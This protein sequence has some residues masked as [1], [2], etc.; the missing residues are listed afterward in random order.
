MVMRYGM[1]DKLGHITYEAERPAFLQIPGAPPPSR[2]YSEETSRDIDHAVRAIVNAAF[3]KA[4][5]ALTER[6]ETLECGARL[7]LEKE[8]LVE[9]DL[10]MLV[11]KKAQASVTQTGMTR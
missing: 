7:L 4:Q 2:T 1:D 5:A 9:D 11:A 10:R 6:R 3:D 8:T